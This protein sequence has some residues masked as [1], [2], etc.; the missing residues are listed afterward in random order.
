MQYIKQVRK[1]LHQLISMILHCIKIRILL[2][3]YHKVSIRFYKNSLNN[4]QE[5][6][7]FA[8]RM[9]LHNYLTSLS[10][11]SQTNFTMDFTS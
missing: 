6:A 3:F 2:V 4:L 9:T 11:Y 7:I 8:L 10:A 1:M 5:Q